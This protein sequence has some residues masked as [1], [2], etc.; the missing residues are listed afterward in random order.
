VAD[1]N[2]NT[3]IDYRYAKLTA[4]ARRKRPRRRL[5]RQGRRRHPSAHAGG[6]PD[7]RQR[8]GELMADLTE[9]GQP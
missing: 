1:R 8:T 6:H 4:P 5:L 3:L 9:H 7:H 2:I